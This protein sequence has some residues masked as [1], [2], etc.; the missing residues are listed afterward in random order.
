MIVA[1]PVV[2]FKGDSPVELA[3]ELEE[4]VKEAAQEGSALYETE[5]KIFE[6]VLKIGH[7]ATEMFLQ[8][9]GDGNLGATCRTEA[10]CRRRARLGK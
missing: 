2:P 6:R 4:L 8:A 1:C 5:R 10:G 3:K 7:A 9:Q